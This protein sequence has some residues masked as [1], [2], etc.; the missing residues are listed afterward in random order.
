MMFMTAPTSTLLATSALAQ[1]VTA[2]LIQYEALAPDA[3]PQAALTLLQEDPGS[4][5]AA[6]ESRNGAKLLIP[7]LRLFQAD[8]KAA[9]IVSLKA[10]QSEEPTA[11]E[12]AALVDPFMSSTAEAL[13]LAQHGHHDS[14]VRGFFKAI[15]MQ[16]EASLA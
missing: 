3:E 2:A 1:G 12:I 7:S 16:L 4:A 14:A 8:A 15:A 5:R 10:S 6:I 13:S 11:E 9:I